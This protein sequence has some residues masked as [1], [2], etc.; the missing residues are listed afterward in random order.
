MNVQQTIEVC[1]EYSELLKKDYPPERMSD[2]SSEY[3]PETKHIWL[4]HA[5]YMAQRIPEFLDE[6]TESKNEKAL[7]WLG[8]L[9][10]IL[11]MS[12]TKTLKE[13]KIANMPKGA[14]YNR[15]A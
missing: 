12:G 13:A 11:N 15:D 3:T 10:G 9:Q 1:I 7:K 4:K 14:V 8:Y 6:G 5:C 2:I